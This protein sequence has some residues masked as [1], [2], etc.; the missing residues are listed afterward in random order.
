VF[1]A[2]SSPHPAPATRQHYNN[3]HTAFPTN[4]NNPTNAAA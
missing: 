3:Q 1:T 2:L 4:H